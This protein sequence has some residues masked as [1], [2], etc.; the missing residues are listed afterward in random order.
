VYI[1]SVVLLSSLIIFSCGQR[2]QYPI[3]NPQI[4]AEFYV[5]AL[6]DVNDQVEAFPSNSELRLKRLYINQ[7]LKW[8]EDAN[9][10]LNALVK[11]DGLTLQLYQFGL[12]FYQAY[13]LYEE[14][15]N[16]VDHWERISGEA[17]L[18]WKVVALK[19]LGRE[20]EAKHFLWQLIQSDKHN[21]QNLAY[22]GETYLAY[23]DTT[24][25]IYAMNLLFQA[26]PDDPFLFKNYVPILLARHHP[27][28]AS[29]VVDY[30]RFDSTDYESGLKRAEVAFQLGQTRKAH[31]MLGAYTNQGVFY[32]RAEWYR[33]VKQYDS[34][35]YMMDILIADDSSQKA[36]LTKGSIAEERGLLYT[37]Y[38][39][40][41]AVLE[42]DSTNSIA[43]E[44]A[45]NVA[46][47]IAYLRS[48]RERESKIPVLEISSKKET[49]NE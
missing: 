13:H 31:Q 36:L 10:D 1:K 22:A 19:G 20:N 41:E 5:E 35:M 27:E 2:R 4:D 49:E 43:Q 39:L 3:E 47:K 48:L 23:G 38:G 44:S 17:Q 14:L 9:E 8:P 29:K 34:A 32:K 42:K 24:R 28:I 7:K 46:R 18:K 6:H 33:S 11:K 40:F 37:A 30:A 25:S 15:L 26:Q 16:L 21:V 12:D 45:Q